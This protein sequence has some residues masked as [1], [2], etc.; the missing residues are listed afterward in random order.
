MSTFLSP[1]G[2]PPAN[3]ATDPGPL[4]RLGFW[5]RLLCRTF[6][7]QVRID[8]EAVDRVRALSAQGSVVYVMRYRSLVDYLL[9]AFILLRERLPLPEFVSDV[10][11]LLLRPLNE[12][13]SILWERL[14]QAR[15]F[16]RAWR[17]VEDRD[18]C[19]RLVRQ[20]RPVLIF[21]RSRAPGVR[22]LEGRR[23]AVSRARSG[24]DYLSE[25]VHAGWSDGQ[26]VFLVPLALTRG[27]GFR[28][29]ES[30]LATLVYSVQEAPGEI[31]RLVSLLW[32]ARETSLSLGSEV[33]LAQFMRE[34]RPEGEARVVRRLARVLQIV[35][36]REERVVLGPELL[37][38]RTV[39]QM[40]V[41]GEELRT[42]IHRLAGERNQPES[43]LWRTAERY[44]G[45][46]AANFH[47]TYFSFLEF[48]FNRV[49]PRVFR[50]FEY[51]G[52]EKVA[53]CVRRHPV[54]LVP[55][56]RSHFDYLILS[57]LFHANY[58][59]PPHIAAGINMSFWPLGPLFRGA[60]A[61]FIRRSFE[62]N[63]LYKCVFRN[64]LTYLIREGYT[65]EFFI[66][67]GRSR[68]GKIL[69]PKLGM[70]SAIVN[71]FIAGVRR[72]LY[73]VPVSIYYERVV[74]EEVYQRELGGAEK[75]KESFW[76]LLKA[77]TV[78]RKKYGTVHVAFA[79]PISLSALLGEGIERL[80]LG[81]GDP[82]IEE[83]RRRFTQKLGF[84]ILRDVNAVTVVGATSVS[85][86]VLLGLPHAACR[87][88]EFLRAAQTLL[89]FLRRQEVRI[90][91]TLE[92]N[93]ED[94]KENLAFLE[95]AGLIQR[96]PGDDAVIHVPP[97][98]RL[99]LDFY[100][101]NSIHFFL[102]P[103]L[104]SRALL[105][106]LHGTAVAEEVTWWLH[107]YRW[108]FPLPE[109]A[110]L[111]DE[112]A[113]LLDYFR[114][115]GAIIPGDGEVVDSH[116]GLLSATAGILDNFAEAYWITAQTMLRLSE[117]GLTQ[118][119]LLEA[120]RQRYSTGLLL[121]EVR[122]P[123]GTSTVTLRNAVSRYTE[124]GFVTASGGSKARERAIAPGPSFADLKGV[125][126]RLAAHLQLP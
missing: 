97:E 14:R 100:K 29:R 53:D 22:L 80:R 17:H 117:R 87:Y 58:L 96:L 83:E 31:K 56:H 92:R 82:A 81:T 112:L 107:L 11:T 50:G 84:R 109:R 32:N 114:S 125:E 35:L 99:I 25:I 21:M 13:V 44:F 64:Y 36:Y 75:E 102:V 57:Y 67:G 121:G 28:R 12:I 115:E 7:S 72:D 16:G 39:R 76:A 15:R 26:E 62:G 124:M 98:K 33:P 86:T 71:A 78:L 74:E 79:D 40:V 85:A 103:A 77:R 68:T 70:L 27:R 8:P 43:Q 41:Q 113:R 46:I 54:V 108:E 59:S 101:N 69:T 105:K 30:R 63:E 95:T 18:R 55:C 116:N 104:L 94:F 24:T 120:V 45:E 89:R 47:S 2:E 48:V 51:Q 111:A 49:W 93:A 91:G 110:T 23:A 106:G 9:V 65:Q 60:G 34:F 1:S 42:L 10:P 90:T 6:F 4:R 66:E 19:Q 118:K 3:A 122:K 61:Y 119:G 52:L 123:E 5:P 73:L 88:A 126:R 37:P 38:K 20:G